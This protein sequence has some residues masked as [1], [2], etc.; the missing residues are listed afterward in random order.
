MKVISEFSPADST[1]GRIK[2][3]G[4]R[5]YYV[6]VPLVASLSTPWESRGG[7]VE[8]SLVG[9]PVTCA[10][11][12]EILVSPAGIY[13]DRSAADHWILF[14]SVYIDLL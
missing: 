1:G 2:N 8:F 5:R 12:I 6:R 3:T 13:H 9:T 14:R 10:V 4:S 11:Q 7:N